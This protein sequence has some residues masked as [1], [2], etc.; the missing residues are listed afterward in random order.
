MSY[1][2][3][4]SEKD[5][6]KSSF[7]YMSCT[8]FSP[9][10]AHVWNPG[11]LHPGWKLSLPQ[12]G[13]KRD[14]DWSMFKYLQISN[15]VSLIFNTLGLCVFFLRLFRSVVYKNMWNGNL[16]L[17]EQDSM[18]I[19]AGVFTEVKGKHDRLQLSHQEVPLNAWSLKTSSVIL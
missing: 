3:Y 9:F 6:N 7:R 4:I 12:M 15:Q 11:S 5:I 13:L 14:Q 17:T 2:V 18:S 1:L 19:R 10:S 8:Y 16:G